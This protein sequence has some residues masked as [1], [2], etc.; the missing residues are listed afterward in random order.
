ML[1]LENAE[2]VSHSQPVSKFEPLNGRKKLSKVADSDSD[3]YK[4]SHGR[5]TRAAKRGVIK[6]SSYKDDLNSESDSFLAED[7]DNYE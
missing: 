2:Q 3:D 1:F 6:K 7:D 5:N 4:P